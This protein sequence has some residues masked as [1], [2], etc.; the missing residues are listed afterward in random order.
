[1]LAG[2]VFFYDEHQVVIKEI[3]LDEYDELTPDKFLDILQ[4]LEI[5]IVVLESFSHNYQTKSNKTVL[6]KKQED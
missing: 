6:Y 5:S 2:T 3:D 1:M 4:K